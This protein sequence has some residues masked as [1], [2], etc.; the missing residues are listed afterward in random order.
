MC[1]LQSD[2]ENAYKKWLEGKIFAH[3]SVT[4]RTSFAGKRKKSTADSH[5]KKHR[6]REHPFR[7]KSAE[8]QSG[9]IAIRNQ[10]PNM[11]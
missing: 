2:C 7:P 8:S 3:T 1:L 4:M 5:M 6:V 11:R 9:K 10:D